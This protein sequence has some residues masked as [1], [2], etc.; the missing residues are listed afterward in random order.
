LW[1]RVKIDGQ[2]EDDKVYERLGKLLDE[3]PKIRIEPFSLAMLNRYRGPHVPRGSIIED[4]WV[5]RDADEFYFV[6]RES[7][8]YFWCLPALPERVPG[9]VLRWNE[10]WWVRNEE[11][12]L[13]GKDDLRT[14]FRA[15]KGIVVTPDEKWIVLVHEGGLSTIDPSQPAEGM[16]AKRPTWLPAL[17]HPAPRF[18]LNKAVFGKALYGIAAGDRQPPAAACYKGGHFARLERRKAFWRFHE[19][20]IILFCDKHGDLKSQRTT[21]HAGKD[22]NLVGGNTT[23]E[24]DV[25]AVRPLGRLGAIPCTAP[26]LEYGDATK[27]RGAWLTVA[28]PRYAAAAGQPEMQALAAVSPCSCAKS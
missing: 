28:F 11:V 22:K 4:F 2:A 16:G 18:H 12:Q 19:G 13:L 9:K 15:P 14:R 20:T 7:Q 8:D 6:S 17:P 25:Y 27:R 24:G 5:S 1:D 23:F 26:V 3:Q 10:V 21:Q